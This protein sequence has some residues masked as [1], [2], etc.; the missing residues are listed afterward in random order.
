MGH[1]SDWEHK[2]KA[3]VAG[4]VAVDSGVL[5][6]CPLHPGSL[7]RGIAL[8]AAA[9]ELARRRYAQGP[10]YSSYDSVHELL[11]YVRQV[12]ADNDRM[13]CEICARIESESLNAPRERKSCGATR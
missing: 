13:A 4:H 5:H 9:Q 3:K 10:L 12:I 7:F 11:G 2:Q 8:P 6:A 1:S